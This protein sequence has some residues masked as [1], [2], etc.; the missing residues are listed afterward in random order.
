LYK[1]ASILI[2]DEPT[3]A[4]D[5]VAEYEF[6]T[7][8]VDVVGDRTAVYMSHRMAS[9]RFC[10]NIIVFNDGEIVQRG[11]HESLLEDENGKY[12]ELWNAQAQY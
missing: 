12:F 7:H 11:S 3:V 6:Y 5:P 8:L 10:D 4:L 9:C 1:D 2:F